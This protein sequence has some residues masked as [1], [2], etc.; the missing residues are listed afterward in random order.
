MRTDPSID[1]LF[2]ALDIDADDRVSRADLH[3]AAAALRW[4][5]NE[6]PLYALLDRLTLAAPLS[7]AD[8]M[9]RLTELLEDHR[10]PYGRVLLAAEPPPPPPATADDRQAKPTTASNAEDVAAASA[11]LLIIDPQRSFTCG[12]W[13]R[14]MGPEAEEQVAPIRAAFNRC[15]E[16]LTRRPVDVVM[17]TRC[18]FPPD[19]YDW[20]E[21][22]ADQIDAA[23]PYFVK[24][25]N[26][27]LWPPTNGFASWI[28]A[29]LHSGRTT[30]VVGGCTLNSCVRV[31]VVE[32]LQR[33]ATEGLKMV[34][35]L[36]LCG[37][38]ASSHQPSPEFGGQSS[39]ETAVQEMT[40]SGALVVSQIRWR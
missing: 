32:T 28:D 14:S 39:V 36:S 19:S 34:V 24:P 7:R 15:G 10:G 11:A 26:S 16:L 17:F 31:T 8:F 18:P 13:M 23:Q 6:A 27:A 12:S 2:D 25:G 5:W 9:E 4:H 35:D 29:L 22:V 21:R 30:L 37:A 33:F 1:D 40:R 20:D 38:R 3:A